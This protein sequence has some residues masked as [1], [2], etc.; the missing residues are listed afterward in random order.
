MTRHRLCFA[1]LA[2]AL[3]WGA[4]E[5][6]DPEWTCHEK[7]GLWRENIGCLYGKDVIIERFE[8]ALEQLL[9]CGRL[10]EYQEWVIS[11]KAIDKETWTAVAMVA[12]ETMA[13]DC[14][15]LELSGWCDK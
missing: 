8:V 15:P 3:F 12:A 2:S 6:A 14:T 4:A 11:L 9:V 5:G 10:K 13:E 1:L 7:G